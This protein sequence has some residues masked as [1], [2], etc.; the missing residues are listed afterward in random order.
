MPSF[1]APCSRPPALTL[2]TAASA[3]SLP[4][5]ASYNGTAQVVELVNA[6]GPVRRFEATATGNRPFDLMNDVSTGVINTAT[7]VGTGSNR[8]VAGNG[9]QLFGSFSVQGI[10][11][12]LP[13]IRGLSGQ[14]QPP[15]AS[16][17]GGAVLVQPAGGVEGLVRR[18]EAR[19]AMANNGLGQQRRPIAH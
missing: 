4:L 17:G 3:A 1:A 18:F 15:L 11:T 5:N 9:D 2:A 6:V 10:A 13:N 7:G 16:Q 8:F 14:A 12:A 19:R